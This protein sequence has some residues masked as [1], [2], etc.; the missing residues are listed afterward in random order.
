MNLFKKKH[1]KASFIAGLAVAILVGGLISYQKEPEFHEHADFAI[2]IDG[3]ELDF[4]DDKYMSF[5]PCSDDVHYHTP[6]EAVHL[7]ENNGDVIHSHQ[8]VVNYGHFINTVM[9]ELRERDDLRFFING[10]EVDALWD[11]KVR[12]LEQVL[13]TNTQGDVSQELEAITNDACI[14]SELCPERGTATYE[15][16]G[17]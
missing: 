6:E 11:K 13:I 9:P 10:E 12:D 7:H 2:V 17:A 4:S 16:C 3:K 14:Y 15:S 5:V 1:S 8:S